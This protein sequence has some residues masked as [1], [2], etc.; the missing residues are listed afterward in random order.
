MDTRLDTPRHPAEKAGLSRVSLIGSLVGIQLILIGLVVA[1]VQALEPGPDLTAGAFSVSY[2]GPLLIAVGVAV[3][4][5][6]RVATYDGGT[7]EGKRGLMR[8]GRIALHLGFVAVIAIAVYL[9]AGPGLDGGRGGGVPAAMI[10]SD[11]VDR[12]R[13]PRDQALALGRIAWTRSAP[14]DHSAD[15][16]HDSDAGAPADLTAAQE[17]TLAAQLDVARTVVP[18]FDTLQEAE[19][20]GYV[21]GSG[22]GDG[23]GSHWIKWSLVDR[24]FDPAVPS[25]LLFDELTLGEGPELIA[26]SYWVSSPETPEGFAGDT[27]TWHRH[28][29]MCFENAWLIGENVNDSASCN[30]DWINGSDLWMLHAW[31]VPGVENRLGQ[32]ASVNPLLCERTCGLEN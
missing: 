6:T 19:A 21:R 18:R 9:V 10:L 14:M 31:V 28:V 12:S 22:E 30:G 8:I 3:V 4:G 7:L 11:G 32:F 2:A 13:L 27:D 17:T 5:V 29:G 24:P 15:H 1:V 25:Q 16:D 20:A 26:F 23:A